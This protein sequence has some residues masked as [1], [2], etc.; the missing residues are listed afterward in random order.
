VLTFTPLLR[1]MGWFLKSLVHETG[2]T[3]MAWFLGCPAV[4]AI[5]LDG[6]AAAVHSA[7]SAPLALVMAAGLG[8]AAWRAPLAPGFRLLLAIAALLHPLLA[9]TGARELLFL[10]A[11]HLGE[12]AFAAYCLRSAAL[13]GFTGSARERIANAAC[14]FYLVG[15]NVRLAGALLLSAGARRGYAESGSFGLT[16]DYLRISRE[17]LHGPIQI[18]AFAMLLVSFAPLLA[19]RGRRPA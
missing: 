3:C 5:R 10:L 6:H 18:V 13:G 14:G 8:V 9:F 15:A 19:I 11:G 7:Q 16:N 12:L 1:Y 17:I 4:P 2:H